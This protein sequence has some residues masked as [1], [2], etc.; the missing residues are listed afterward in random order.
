M[1]KNQKTH[2][3]IVCAIYTMFMYLLL[4][5]NAVLLW[6]FLLISAF[7]ISKSVS[8]VSLFII[9]TCAFTIIKYTHI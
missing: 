9:V 3:T 1:K 2:S 5:C 6:V 8:K 4:L 7:H